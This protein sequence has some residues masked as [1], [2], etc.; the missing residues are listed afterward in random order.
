MTEFLFIILGLFIL[1][2][3][4]DMFVEN[5]TKLARSLGISELLIGMTISSIG[6]S[7]PELIIGVLS[8][9]NEKHKIILADVL[10]SNITDIIL[11]LGI[12]GALTSIKIEKVVVFNELFYSLIVAL[13]TFLIASDGV[14]TWQEGGIL[15]SV[16]LVYLYF[17]LKA[18]KKF[19]KK[20]EID[21]KNLAMTLVSLILV[22][23]GGKILL[24]SLEIISTKYKIGEFILTFFVLSLGTSIPELAIM[25]VGLLK[26]KK[27]LAIG[28]ILGSIIFNTCVVL[29]VSALIFP[30]ITKNFIFDFA[31]FGLSL[32]LIYIVLFIVQK[33]EIGI[34]ESVLFLSAYIY[35]VFY[36]ISR[37]L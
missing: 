13:I 37:G 17:I 5:S 28:T 19:G 9:F 31:Y 35:Y 29:G 16:Y 24:W 11:G 25:I 4:S 7:I 3:S 34:L 10:G 33:Y 14:I 20:S 12:C 32:A 21:F 27:Q 6:T 15:I 23:I 1:I 36:I 8:A 30:I 2:K 18:F 26:E 22:Y